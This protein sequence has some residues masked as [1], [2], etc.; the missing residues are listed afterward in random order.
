MPTSGKKYVFFFFGWKQRLTSISVFLT[1]LIECFLLWSHISR[2]CDRLSPL[3][4]PTQPISRLEKLVSVFVCMWLGNHMHAC[5][6][7]TDSHWS[8]DYAL[9]FSVF[10]SLLL[11]RAVLYWDQSDQLERFMSKKNRKDE[12]MLVEIIHLFLQ[13]L[14]PFPYLSIIV[15]T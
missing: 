8:E 4:P 11:F 12:E 5:Q 1:V 14:K 15:L 7:Q 2:T 13:D 6:V 9:F 10:L 3:Q